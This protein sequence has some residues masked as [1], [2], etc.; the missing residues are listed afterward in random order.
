M[1]TEGVSQCFTAGRRWGSEGRGC[2]GGLGEGSAKLGKKE[3]RRNR[4]NL[5]FWRREGG[6][7][8][9]DGASVFAIEVIRVH[10]RAEGFAVRAQAFFEHVVHLCV[11]KAGKAGKRRRLGGPVQDGSDGLDPDGSALKPGFGLEIAGGVARRVA[12]RAA[13]NLFDQVSASACFIR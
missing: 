4:E 13:G 3:F 6:Q 1:P 11:G 7:V 10:G 8:G 2:G 12:L 5:A 9:D